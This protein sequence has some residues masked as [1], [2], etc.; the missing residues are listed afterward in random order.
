NPNTKNKLVED[1]I[2]AS[3]TRDHKLIVTTT[4]DGDSYG[5]NVQP[6]EEI[7]WVRHVE[8]F[9]WYIVA[10]VK[11]DEL[12]QSS[13][14]LRNKILLLAAIVVLFSIV[15][16]SLMM[17]RLLLPVRKLS[18]V[19][20]LVTEGDLS[21]RSDIEGTDEISFLAK[22]FNTM[23]GRLKDN[24]DELDHKVMERTQELD[25][26]N[27]ELLLTVGQLEQHNH[28]VTELNRMAERLQACYGVEE[29][30]PVAAEAMAALFP[31]SSGY[32]YMAQAGGVE[33]VFDLVIQWGE[34]SELATTVAKDDCLAFSNF[35][36]HELRGLE[37]EAVCDHYVPGEHGLSFC[38]PLFAQ[39][40][41]M[42]MLHLN[43]KE[44]CKDDRQFEH[45]KRL[46]ASATDHLAM[47]MANLK[48]RERLQNL[49]V[50]D[51]LTGLFNRRYMEET[52]SREFKAYERTKHPVGVIIL[53][54]DFFKK[55]NDTYGHEAGDLVLIELG[56]VLS[57]NVRKEDVV[58]R[59]GGEEFVVIL[60]GAPPEQAL[61]R[62]ELLRSKVETD[63]RLTYHGHD[64]R[65]TISLGAA[66]FPEHGEAPDQ[67]LKAADTALYRAKEAGRNRA[68]QATVSRA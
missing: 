53:D 1:L 17:G 60:L 67:V 63:L 29:T 4:M 52:L 64:I 16:V 24:I 65:V 49:S 3:N 57:A 26:A 61:V 44:C 35:R 40:D 9:D 30:Y 15:V 54:V 37:G 58:C 38:V 56:K 51:G 5:A 31:Q 66:S 41:V 45:Q 14:V 7:N 39:N 22:T 36:I 12:N 46:V 10:S 33:N 21:A 43:I 13:D 47:S 62:A 27:Q 32:L 34:R 8:G 50:R 28:E 19:A 2:A 18:Q 68:F 55:F 6:H 23:V 25:G 42:G 48:L 59:F 11:T 20:R